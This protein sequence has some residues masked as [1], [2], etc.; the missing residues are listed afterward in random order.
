MHT[1]TH[2]HTHNTCL[3][4]VSNITF[5]SFRLPSAKTFQSLSFSILQYMLTAWLVLTVWKLFWEIWCRVDNIY[6]YTQSFAKNS[7]QLICIHYIATL[8]D[9]FEI[10]LFTFDVETF[11][12]PSVRIYFI[13][14]RHVYV[15]L[16]SAP[17]QHRWNRIIFKVRMKCDCIKFSLIKFIFNATEKH[18]H[19]RI[20]YTH[21]K[22]KEIKGG[23]IEIYI[24][25]VNAYILSIFVSVE[26]KM[27]KINNE[28][29][30]IYGK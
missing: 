10:W 25:F 15:R 8:T 13:E 23:G 9:A 3:F 5:Y 4:N 7:N 16:R 19:T 12:F 21:P 24:D 20:R 27:R 29:H 26:R 18:T 6:L 2:T 11:Y 28:Q 14:N 17:W 1:Q 30:Y 22:W